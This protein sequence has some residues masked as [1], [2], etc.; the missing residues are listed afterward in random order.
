[1]SLKKKKGGKYRISIDKKSLSSYHSH[2]KGKE[3]K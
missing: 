3:M 2:M 1:M